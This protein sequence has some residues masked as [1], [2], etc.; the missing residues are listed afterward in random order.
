M[1]PKGWHL[2]IRKPEPFWSHLSVAGGVYLERQDKL[3]LFQAFGQFSSQLRH[4][5]LRTV[6]ATV[7]WI[8]WHGRKCKTVE[9]RFET[10]QQGVT[11]VSVAFA[12]S[13]L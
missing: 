8:C 11:P 4:A 1:R 13:W 9:T 2:H 6:S 10:G 5:L 12:I 3:Q 7:L